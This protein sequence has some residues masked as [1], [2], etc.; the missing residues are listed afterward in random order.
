MKAAAGRSE[1]VV[2]A[3]DLEARAVARRLLRGCR[4]PPYQARVD[5][6]RH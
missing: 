1:I 2:D 6:L 5:R 3:F 4:Q